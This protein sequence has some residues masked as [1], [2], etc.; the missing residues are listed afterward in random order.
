MDFPQIK[1]EHPEEYAQDEENKS[2]VHQF[3][4]ET[5]IIWNPE[6]TI[7]YENDEEMKTVDNA[8]ET[9]IPT[10]KV[11][12]SKEDETIKHEL[13][14]DIN[15][16]EPVTPK[17]EKE[18][19]EEES[20]TIV[21][22]LIGADG[23][24]PHEDMNFEDFIEDEDKTREQTFEHGENDVDSTN[25]KAKYK[26]SYCE[27]QTPY[28][29]HLNKHINAVHFGIKRHKCNQ[30]DYQSSAKQNL[31][32]HI[33]IHGGIKNHE[34]SHC[35]FRTTERSKLKQHIDGVHLGIKKYKCS[36]CDYKTTRTTNLKRHTNGLHLGIKTTNVIIVIIRQLKENISR[37]I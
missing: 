18:L 9:V 31:Q 28:R 1:L 10:I 17:T 21:H 3:I 33:N 24:I 35:D 22:E 34:C 14:T 27:Y 8:R 7:K 25:L 6:E 12:I 16:G 2:F 23:K 15:G 37:S 30:C 20:K 5:G 36:Y 11:E 4:D 29:G 32:R 19:S 26:C 13:T